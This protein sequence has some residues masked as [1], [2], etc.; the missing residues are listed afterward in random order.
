M[1]TSTR[2]PRHAWTKEKDGTLVECLMELV[3]MEEWKSDNDTFRLGYLAQLICMMAEKL[4]GFRVR[5]TTSHPATKGLPNK[6]FSY[7]DE[8][9]YVF[10]RDRTTGQFV[11]TFA[12]VG[13][14]EP[15]G[16]EGFDMAGGNEEFPF[17]YSQGIDMS[18]D[19]V[20]TLRPSRVSDGMTG[21]SGSKR[22]RESQQKVDVEGI[23]LALD[24]TNEQ[25]R[26]IT[27][28]PACALANETMCARNSSAY[29]VRCRNSRVWIERYCKGIF[30]LVWTTFGVSY[31]CLRM[32]GRDFVE[33]SYET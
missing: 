30:C 10:D 28:W 18:Q 13:F 22:K 33:S 20:C 4:P 21:S 27:E 32:R 25:L 16:Y 1:S 5:A 17:V 2:A 29:C 24:Q 31:S 15:G 9:T 8:L 12:D 26:M 3:L 19:D 11:E 6:P 14:N 23:H 7:Y